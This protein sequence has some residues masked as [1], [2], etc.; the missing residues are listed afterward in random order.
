[1]KFSISCSDIKIPSVIFADVDPL[2]DKLATKKLLDKN[3]NSFLKKIEDIINS[4]CDAYIYVEFKS[5]RFR[6]NL[7]PLKDLS[8]NDFAK[9]LDDYLCSLKK[10]VGEST[11]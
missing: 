8:A 11:C 7:S 9:K 3:G 4:D 2:D 1:M 10:E 6:A 5:H